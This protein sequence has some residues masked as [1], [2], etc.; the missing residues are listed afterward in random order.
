MAWKCHR[1]F[2]PSHLV[3][4]GRNM[5]E[6]RPSAGAWGNWFKHLGYTSVRLGVAADGHPSPAAANTNGTA[7][8]SGGQDSQVLKLWHTI[9]EKYTRRSLSEHRDRLPALSAIAQALMPRFQCRYHA[10]LWAR[11]LVLE[12]TWNVERVPRAERA[13]ELQV[14]RGGALVVVGLLDEKGEVYESSEFYEDEVPMLPTD[15]R[16]DGDDKCE[17]WCLL[18][19]D[20]LG[21]LWRSGRKFPHRNTCVMMVL[22]KVGDAKE[23]R[24]RRVGIAKASAERPPFWWEASGKAEVTVI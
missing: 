22:V 14:R 21:R 11:F 7:E 15:P 8:E 17:A 2:Q 16:K 19:T 6:R 18:L 9:V 1:G 4:N 5:L 20:S 23:P 24:Y 3:P 10:G 12:L 13:N